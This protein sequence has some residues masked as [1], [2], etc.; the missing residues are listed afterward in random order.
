MTRI[1][2]STSKFILVAAA[3]L[4]TTA[5]KA[6]FSDAVV[7]YLQGNYEESMNQMKGLASTADDPLAM[8]YI[9]VMLDKGQGTEKDEKE[10]AEWLQLASENGI[11]PAQ[12][13]LANKYY[14]GSGVPKDYERAYAWYS[15]AAAHGH[16]PSRLAI[17]KASSKLD[18]E[19][20]EA[21]EDLAEG[22]MHRYG[23]AAFPAR[24]DP[25][26]QDSTDT[27]A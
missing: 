24:E 11:A 8:Y 26:K 6:D 27:P 4:L 18:Q 13:K 21:A 1:M 7:L 16:G 23:P 20:L 15:T 5:A 3:L 2:T 12:Y 19:E 14:N 9:G 22:Y 25:A 10:A 17:E